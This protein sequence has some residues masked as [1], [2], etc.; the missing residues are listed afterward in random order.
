[1]I[2]WITR[3]VERTHLEGGLGDSHHEPHGL[4]GEGREETGRDVLE[5]VEDVCVCVTDAGDELG[6]GGEELVRS[7]LLGE[8]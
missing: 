4:L 6:E 1:M 2:L 5:L 3:K 8:P 7:Q